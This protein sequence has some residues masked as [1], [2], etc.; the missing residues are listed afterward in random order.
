MPDVGPYP[1][2]CA[3]CKGSGVIVTSTNTNPPIHAGVPATANHS[4]LATTF[5]ILPALSLPPDF[6]GHD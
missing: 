6:I 5:D 3:R 1:I 2:K 4:V